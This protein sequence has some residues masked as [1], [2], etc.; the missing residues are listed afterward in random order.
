M[1]G[2]VDC[3]NVSTCSRLPKEAM[4]RI[5]S[6]G[7]PSASGWLSEICPVESIRP[8]RMTSVA[9]VKGPGAEAVMK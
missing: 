3:L 1:S 9:T 6:T 2:G 4:A 8:Q 5:R 7:T